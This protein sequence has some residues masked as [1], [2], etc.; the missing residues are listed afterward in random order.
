MTDTETPDPE[1]DD[2]MTRADVEAIA[3]RKDSTGRW[4][5]EL[6]AAKKAGKLD[7]L[8]GSESA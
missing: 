3:A 5:E 7:R 8:L 4:A 6:V 2:Q 1:P